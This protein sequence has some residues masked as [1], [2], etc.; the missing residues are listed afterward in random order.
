MTPKTTRITLLMLVI[1]L[2]TCTCSQPPNWRGLYCSIR[3][4]GQPDP[5]WETCIR[6]CLSK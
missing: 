4:H 1:L 6:T 3:C 2:A 5:H